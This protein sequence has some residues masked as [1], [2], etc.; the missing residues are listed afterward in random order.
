MNKQVLARLSLAMLSLSFLPCLGQTDKDEWRLAVDVL[1]GKDKTKDKTWAV[2]LLMESQNYEKDAFVQNV[3]GIAFLH[4]L[5]AEPDTMKAITYFE[6]SGSMGYPLAYH[7]LGMYYK[8]AAEGKQD[9]VKAYEAFSKGAEAEDPSCC[10]NCGFM[11]YKGLGC[12]QDYESAIDHFSKAADFNHA[13]S[14]FM[15]GLCFRNGYGVDADTAIGNAY[16]LQSADLGFRDAME[17][18]LNNEPE[19]KTVS[20]YTFAEESNDVPQEMPQITPYLPLNSKVMTGYYQGLLVT[21]DWSGNYVISEKP[22]FVNMSV[23]RDTATGIWIQGK[24]TVEFAAEV[25]IDGSFNFEGT[26]KSL[27]DRYSPSFTSHYR[28]EKVDMNYHRGYIT[29]QLRLYS[30]DEMEPERPMY[31]SL[32]KEGATEDGYDEAEYAKIVA[33]S[34]PYSDRITLKFELSQAVPSANI[35]I[36]DRTSLNVGNYKC[37]SLNAG[38]NSVVI[39]PNL[40]DGYYVIN[41]VAGSQKFQAVI[42]L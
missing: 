22:L 11:K 4:G 39:T 15:L 29:G 14:I 26:E 25:G 42:V 7:N 2:N 3:L 23:A 16:L 34:D 32:H 37:G 19:N 41:V 33:Y 10:Y 12:Q 6:E 27:F 8:Y 35:S 30:L 36:Y 28:F 18:L 5:G 17:E 38:I 24:D 31:I 21:Y 40:K 9:F 20:S 1:K 13:P